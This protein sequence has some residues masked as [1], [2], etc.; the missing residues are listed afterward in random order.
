MT[1]P[2]SIVI[3]CLDDVDLLE[4]S[5]PPLVAELAHRGFGDE[6]V[7]VDD[8]GSDVLAAW[9]AQ[10]F[11]EARVVA[12]ARNEGF[13]RALLAGMQAA[14]HDLVFSMNPDVRVRA[15]FLDPLVACVDSEEVWAVA[16]R[17]LLG[18]RE[19]KVE[20]FA[21]LVFEHGLARISQPALD[22]PAASL[23]FRPVPVSFAVGGASLLR[24]RVFLQRG[25]FDPLFEPF[26]WEDVDYGW[27]A[28]AAGGRVVY[29]PASVVEHHHRGTIGRVVPM[30]L[31]RAA[32]EKN[33]LLF[34]WKHLDDPELLF[35]HV[36]AL[37]RMAIDAW[38]GEQR[39]VL[40]WMNLALDQLD[41]ALAA[42][43]GG[44][45]VRRTFREILDA[46]TE[47]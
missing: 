7:I 8:T 2:V 17:L 19:G 23:P 30:G 10:R 29:Q 37:Y 14:R 47:R 34:H 43:G 32:I 5:L 22:E 24:R 4:A 44:D 16:P 11:P 25:G 9:V 40:V 21:D 46:S 26:Y 13:A 35:E 18:G 41:A 31:V 20:S 38:I 6:I 3:P 42:R 39:E 27:R 15:G 45:E 1:R 12:L 33:R 36:V 28:W